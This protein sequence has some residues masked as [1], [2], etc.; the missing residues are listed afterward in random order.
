MSCGDFD[1]NLLKREAREKGFFVP[2]YMKRWINIKKVFPNH[3]FEKGKV[4]PNFKDPQTIL[5]A[6]TKTYGMTS[7]LE[8]CEIEL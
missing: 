4:A 3:L 8:R 2:S 1:G 5:N 7:M 6:K